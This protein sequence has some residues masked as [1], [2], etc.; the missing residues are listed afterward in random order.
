[1]RTGAQLVVLPASWGEGPGKAQQWDLLVRA[2]AM[3]AQ[4]WLL[5]C[6]QAWTPPQGSAPLG[7]GRSALVDPTGGVRARLTHE[8]DVL[9]ADIDLGLVERTRA[10]VPVVQ[11]AH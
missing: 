10:L 7:L 1:M 5:A 8:P 9:V 4:A 11:P 6:D 3:D 2:R